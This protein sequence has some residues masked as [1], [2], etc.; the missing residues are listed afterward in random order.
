MKKTRLEIDQKALNINLDEQI[1]GTFAEIGAGQEVARYF[2]Q[3]GAAAG[4]IAKTMSAYDKTYSDEIYG[5]EASG[6][7]VCESRV[8]KMLD[9]EYG[10]LINR[11]KTNRPNSKF[12]AFADTIAA[13]NYTGSISG[14]GWLG[15]RFQQ[16]VD[17]PI[18]DVVLHVKMLDNDTLLQQQAV[19]IL[20]VNLIYAAFFLHDDIDEFLNS[21]LDGLGHRIMVDMIRTSGPVFSSIGGKELCFKL[22]KHGL[23]IVAM[24]DQYG[25]SVHPSEFMYRKHV[26]VV[27]GAFKPVTWMSYDMFVDSFN[28]FLIDHK[29]SNEKT[30]KLAEMTLDILGGSN[31]AR[32]TDFVQR[33][34]VLNHLGFPVCISKGGNQQLLINYLDEFKCPVIGLSVTAG[35][36][37]RFFD[38]IQEKYLGK[39][40]LT[41]MGEM[42]NGKTRMYVYPSLLPGGKGIM[43]ARDIRI[44]NRMKFLFEHLLETK[45][46]VD[47]EHYQKENLSV[48]AHKILSMIKSGNSD[49]QDFVPPQVA[50]I[51]SAKHLF[52]D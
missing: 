17:G 30:V 44:D 1:Y 6:R 16:H 47:V 21:L 40:L 23:S 50:E 48:S 9:H 52:K 18:N 25:N 13:R 42:F 10:L 28:Q 12:F 33:T 36:A 7:Y 22:I 43:K 51:I 29:A 49:W 19:G 27:R 41:G 39:D 45:Q 32:E 8:Y 15:I 35:V 3:A 37:A 20:G 14:D 5:A 4:T 46:I 26:F 34:E 2:F 11:L 31:N 24:V 38:E